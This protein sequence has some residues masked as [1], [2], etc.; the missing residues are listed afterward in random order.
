MVMQSS[1]LVRPKKL[2]VAITFHFSE[3]RLLCLTRVASQFHLLAD[4]ISVWIVTNTTNKVQHEQIRS[5]TSDKIDVQIAVPELLGHPYLLTWSHLEV[6]RRVFNGDRKVSHFMYIEDDIF[7]SARNISYWLRGREGLRS[8]GLIPSF[9]RVEYIPLH[10]N[11]YSTDVTKRR[12]FRGLPRAVISDTY[13]YVNFPEPYQGM[14][15]LDRELAEE[16][17]FGKS[18]SPDF[19]RWGIRE[20]AAQGLTFK[21]VPPG[22]F[23]R[24]F[25]GY[26]LKDR[27]IDPDA[28]IHHIPNNYALDS[29][30]K[31][32]KI[33]VNDLIIYRN[34]I[35]N[36][37]SSNLAIYPMSMTNRLRSF[38]KN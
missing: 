17:F 25:V 4:E 11:P 7:V 6:F 31:F 19:G 27:R 1:D 3:E 2:S 24:N 9:L 37:P 8:R 21:N 28:L 30:T 15:M 34:S 29:R 16:H 18:S 5:A 20:R 13:C 14:Y 32:G 23:S 22:C 38:F 12:R 26:R 36:S 10:E 35:L 33:L